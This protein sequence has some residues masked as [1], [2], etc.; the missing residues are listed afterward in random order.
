[1]DYRGIMENLIKR[2]VRLSPVRLE[3]TR[4]INDV[5]KTLLAKYVG[6]KTDHIIKVDTPLDLS[7]VFEIQ[8]HLR[9]NADLFYEKRTPRFP[10]ALDARESITSQV[11][12]KDV[13]LSYPY[14]SFKPFIKLLNE[15]ATDESVVSIKITL[16]RVAAKSEVV[17]A[18]AE[19]A[20]NGKEVV[21]MVELRARFDEANNIDMSRKLEDAGC[22]VIYGLEK[23]KVHS[24]LCL[25]TRSNGD[26]ISYIT[27][28]GTGNYNEK[29]SK[30]YTDLSLITAD[31]NMG[32][33]AAS[34][35]NALLLGDTVENSN[36][37][38][39]APHC[40]QSRIMELIDEQIELG[41][42]GY[43]GIKINSLTDKDIIKKLIQASKSGVRIEM[44]V[45]GICCLVP[46]IKGE[47]ENITIISVVGRFL[48]HSRIYRFGKG[49]NDKIFIASADFMTRNTTRRVEVAAPVYDEDAKKRLRHIFDTVMSDNEK[50]KMLNSKGLYEDR[51]K[52]NGT[53]NSQEIFYK[54]SYGEI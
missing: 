34:V 21:V 16:Y 47:T 8:N 7:F 14:E 52:T 18:L 35:F 4:N 17:N 37:L 2:R 39:V 24:K 31:Y 3:L 12:K 5:E 38:L 50:G 53:I 41:C 22:R 40:L 1:M 11:L 28:V 44:I 20:E 36:P 46:Q 33:S 27:Q 49:E 15:A 25:I 10:L 45:R 29:T 23:Y 19:A 13:L 26:N 54:E 42:D 51:D 9:E 43:I 48:E 6:I 32:K 30:L